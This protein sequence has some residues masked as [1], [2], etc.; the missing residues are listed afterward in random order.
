MFDL[1]LKAVVTFPIDC[2]IFHRL[3]HF[4]L[5]GSFF[6]EG[7]EALPCTGYASPYITW[8]SL[9]VPNYQAK[10]LVSI[11]KVTRSGKAVRSR[12]LTS[13]SE[14]HHY[15][16][17]ALYLFEARCQSVCPDTNIPVCTRSA[18]L[19]W[20]YEGFSLA[21]AGTRWQRN[22]YEARS[23]HGWG[24][25]VTHTRHDRNTYEEWSCHGWGTM[26]H[27]CDAPQK[28]GRFKD[29]MYLCA[30]YWSH[31]HRMDRHKARSRHALN[32]FVSDRHNGWIFR[33]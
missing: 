6:V 24:T 25:I 1:F 12:C 2:Y 19:D 10:Y 3:W 5:V 32:N 26:R 9:Q 8:M 18:R 13:R 27:A 28:F 4:P 11:K 7:H 29:N 31:T 33:G 23:W 20:G 17:R 14:P 21:E 16:L 22:P 15:A 30:V